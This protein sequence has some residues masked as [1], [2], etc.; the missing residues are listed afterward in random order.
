MFG[1][2]E[3]YQNFLDE[4]HRS[5]Y[6]SVRRFA[7]T[8]IA[9]YVHEWEEA[10]EFPRDLY[11]KAAQA[12]LLGPALPEQYGGGGGDILHA[13]L[14]CEGILWGK[15]TGVLAGLN[16]MAIAAPPI[17]LLGSEE[18][19]K[20]FL[21]SLAS[22]EMIAALGVSE[23]NAGSDV[24]GI[25]TRAV[26]KGDHYEI[27]GAKTFI[28]S[29]V[30]ADLVT[31]LV[32]TGPDPYNGLTFFVVERGTPGFAASAKLKKM[33]WWA[34]DTAELTFDRCKVPV[35]NRL[36]EEGTGFKAVMDGFLSERIRLASYGHATAE[37]ALAEAERYVKERKA[38][39]KDLAEFQVIQHKLARMATL[40]RASKTL[41]YQCG[42]A[43]RRGLKPIEAVCSAKNFAY[44]AAKEVCDHAVQIHGGMGFMRETAVERLYR[45]VRLLGIGGG[46]YEI[47]NEII[48]KQRE[49][50]QRTPRAA[51]APEAQA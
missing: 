6:A 29:G 16:S 17:L 19:K 11:R 30:R 51:R 42:D 1:P 44:E 28:T 43:I 40:V 22:G 24:A 9:P 23:P 39:G 21:P 49:I 38:F 41:N 34:S 15:S 18:Q 31:T 27:S 36:G 47:M 5:F 3:F 14:F 45:D 12:G 2:E 32:R 8:E 46:T 10:G 35:S 13:M 7:E 37:V 26:R 50:K 48:A 25:Q 33:G 4:S 20:R